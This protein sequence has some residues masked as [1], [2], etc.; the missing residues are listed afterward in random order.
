[1]REH[2]K[3]IETKCPFFEI[4]AGANFFM[5]TPFLYPTFPLVIGNLVNLLT[6]D[7]HSQE[8]IIVFIVYGVTVLT[9]IDFNNNK[10]NY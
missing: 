8:L 5:S 6:C 3:I 10:Y 9:G 4:A 1:M 2:C 7:R